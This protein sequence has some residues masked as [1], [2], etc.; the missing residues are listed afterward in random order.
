MTQ[1]AVREQHFA[2]AGVIVDDL[3]EPLGL[4]DQVIIV[5]VSG[6][7][8]GDGPLYVSE[9]GLVLPAQDVDHA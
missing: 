5:W 7:D 8:A 4:W 6:S 9:A 3:G 2:A 1:T